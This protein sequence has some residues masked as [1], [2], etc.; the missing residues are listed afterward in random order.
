MILMKN[1]VFV[2]LASFIVACVL[3]SLF[4]LLKI[5]GYFDF[6]GKYGIER[7]TSNIYPNNLP[8]LLDGEPGTAWG[9][10]DGWV[11]GKGDWLVISFRKP[12]KL[13][14]LKMEV[15]NGMLPNRLEFYVESAPEVW[16]NIHPRSQDYET[17]FFSFEERSV[18][19]LKVSIA[20]DAEK[21]SWKITELIINEK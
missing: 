19:A 1:R 9:G 17:G 3:F 11:N 6:T 21:V 20:E 7:L 10:E 16:E 4:W 18:Y 15:Y 12:V 13:S 8:L 5:Y 2:E 14:S